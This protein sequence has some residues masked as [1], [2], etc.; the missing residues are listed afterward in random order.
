VRNHIVAALGSIKEEPKIAAKL[1]VI[2]SDDASYRTRANALQSLGKLKAPNALPALIAAV[3]ADS[4]DDF[5]RNAALRSLG[6]LGDDKGVPLLREW[7][8]PG[9]PIETRIAAIASLGR[10]E[11]SNKEITA[12]IASYLTESHIR[13]DMQLCAR[14]GAAAMRRPYPRC[15]RCS[16][17][18][19]SASKWRPPSSSK[20]R[21]CRKPTVAK[22]AATEKLTA[23]KRRCR[24][25][26][27]RAASRQAGTSSTGNER[28]AESIESYLAKK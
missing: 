14:W 13:C 11:K 10:L 12:Q 18:T 19:I 17:E 2:A 23:K 9:K 22:G 6:Y 1:L 5:L 20:S 7:S 21:N 24:R 16:K 4:P 27:C 28:P 15:K 3:N 8:A 26:R 25:A